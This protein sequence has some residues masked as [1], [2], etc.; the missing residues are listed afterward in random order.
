[1]SIIDKWTNDLLN[2][3]KKKKRKK[4]LRKKIDHVK[5]KKEEAEKNKDD[6]QFK[7]CCFVLYDSYRKLSEYDDEENSKDYEWLAEKHL[8]L[9]DDIV[10]ELSSDKGVD[11]NTKAVNSEIS[12]D[13][14]D[15]SLDDFGVLIENP[16]AN[17]EN[18]VGGYDKHKQYFKDIL[19]PRI[20]NEEIFEEYYAEDFK[21]VVFHGPSGTGK[22]NFAKAVAGELS[23]REP[24]ISILKAK[25]G[26]IRDSALAS[27]SENVSILFEEA[28]KQQPIILLIEEFDGLVSSREASFNSQKHEEDSKT[29]NTFLDEVTGLEGEQVYVIG[30]TN[31]INKVDSAVIGSHRLDTLEFDLP[32]EKARREILKLH[33]NRCSHLNKNGVDLDRWAELTEGLAGN[34]LELLVRRAALY[35]TNS[36][37]EN[38]AGRVYLNDEYIRKVFEEEFSDI[39]ENSG[40]L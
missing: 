10:H 20:G 18:D 21:G 14:E 26:M 22:S 38:R 8:R 17:F 25:S 5:Q 31:F 9:S 32:G 35:A 39:V 7:K 33:L 4:K 24:D 28:K 2:G 15:P 16:G 19:F 30:T 23:G 34:D 36:H 11:S 27:S 1:M 3:V 29:V 13:G 12:S 40:E 6:E 37:L